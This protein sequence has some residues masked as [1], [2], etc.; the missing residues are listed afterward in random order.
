MVTGVFAQNNP[1]GVSSWVY[2]T[3]LT[4]AQMKLGGEMDMDDNALKEF[5]EMTWKGI[6]K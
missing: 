2:N 4:P 3:I 5:I 1:V 6:L